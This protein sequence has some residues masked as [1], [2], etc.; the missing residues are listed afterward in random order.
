MKKANS[1]QIILILI[2]ITVV[3]LTIGLS[4]ISRTITDVRIS[5]Q[6]E[7]SSKAFSAA[8]A[9]IESALKSGQA[10][11]TNTSLQYA[12]NLNDQDSKSKA[13]YQITKIGGTNSVFEFPLTSPG[14]S[15]TLWLI[16]HSEDGSLPDLASA[17]T[18]SLSTGS[19]F[20]NDNSIDICWG[21]NAALVLTLLYQDSEGYKIA[22]ATY[23]TDNTRT[24]TNNFTLVTKGSNFCNLSYDSKVSINSYNGSKPQF[25]AGNVEFNTLLSPKLILL[26][27]QPVYASTSI[28]AKPNGSRSLPVQGKQITSV[29]YTDTGVVRKIQVSQ[30]FYTLPEMFNF[31]YYSQDN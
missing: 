20:P 5:S 16:D 31:A 24:P 18:Y 15:Q 11:P 4:L 22:K 8:E 25:V 17:V 1:G 2:L 12:F 7:Q 29:G 21:N 28:A 30:G 27:I 9:G 14:N 3:G 6:I 19:T 13:T 10:I 26:R 23:D